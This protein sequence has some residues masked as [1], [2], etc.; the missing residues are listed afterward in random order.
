MQSDKLTIY[1]EILDIILLFYYYYYYFIIIFLIEWQP[2]IKEIIAGRRWE[3]APPFL[4]LFLDDKNCARIQQ[5]SFRYINNDITKSQ[6]YFREIPP[7]LTDP[8]LGPI[9][10]ASTRAIC[11]K[12]LA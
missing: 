12:G 4:L 1:R 11:V 6:Q 10:S 9:P 2:T 7:M 8:F 5:P 3:M